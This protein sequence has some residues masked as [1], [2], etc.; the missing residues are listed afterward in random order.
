MIAKRLPTRTVPIDFSSDA[1]RF[2]VTIPN[3]TDVTVEGIQ[4]LGQVWLENVAHPASRK[5]AAA[6]GVSS[7]YQDHSMRFE[8]SG[9]NGHFAPISWSNG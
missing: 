1:G 5:L 6:K 9:R 7:H 8:N 4:S 2:N 3:V